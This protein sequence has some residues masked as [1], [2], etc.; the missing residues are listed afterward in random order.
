MTTRFYSSDSNPDPL[1]R[2]RDS[3]LLS[4]GNALAF[5]QKPSFILYHARVTKADGTRKGWDEATE[6]LSN[7]SSC[8]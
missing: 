7:A 6:Y 1:A 4:P 2:L 5:V 3:P 8:E